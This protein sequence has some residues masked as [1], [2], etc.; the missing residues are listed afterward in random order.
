MRLSKPKDLDEAAEVAVMFESALK[1][2]ARKKGAHLEEVKE[3]RA[4]TMDIGEDKT[5][6]YNEPER[7]Q[8]K[9]NV[10]GLQQAKWRNKDL[11]S[12]QPGSNTDMEARMDA[13][14]N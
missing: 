7:K 4:V 13:M 12:R 3:I 1:T 8:T 11:F 2:E 14:M 5:V 10:K 6:N 9:G